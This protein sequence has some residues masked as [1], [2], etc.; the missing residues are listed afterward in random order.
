MAKKNRCGGHDEQPKPHPVGYHEARQG[1][2]TFRPLE[3]ALK[4]LA[5]E[6]RAAD[7][8]EQEKQRAAA[9]A[10]AGAGTGGKA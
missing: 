1:A 5:E 4:K 9:A 8:A 7:K 2:P 3:G 10:K 6:K